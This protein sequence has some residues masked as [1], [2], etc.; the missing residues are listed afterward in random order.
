VQGR[1][2]DNRDDGTMMMFRTIYSKRDKAP[3]WR[4]KKPREKQHEV[5]T[6]KKKEKRRRGVGGK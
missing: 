3:A 2:R 1:R 4:K 5:V 6:E